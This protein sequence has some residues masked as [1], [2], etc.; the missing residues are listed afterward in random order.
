MILAQLFDFLEKEI[1]PFTSTELLW[2]PY[3]GE[4]PE[5]DIL[6]AAKIRRQNLKNYLAGFPQKPRLLLV[7]EAPGPW[8]C[9]FSGIP[10]TGERQFV[11]GDLLLQGQPTSTFE[12]PVLERSGTVVW[13]TI[14]EHYPEFFLWN[15]IPYHPTNPGEPLSIRTPKRSEV[16]QFSPL[17]KTFIELLSPKKVIAIGRKAEQVLMLINIPAIYIRHPSFG[18]VKAFQDGIKEIIR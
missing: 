12:P 1:F 18:G 17:L 11:E 4:H 3:L 6:N 15:C 2:N 8:G 14:G 9:R 5:L 13:Q 10:F 7:G 16:V